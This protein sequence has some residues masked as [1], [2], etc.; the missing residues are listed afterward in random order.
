MRGPGRRW[1]GGLLVAG[2]AL[3]VAAGSCANGSPDNG[4]EDAGR[5]LRDGTTG[6]GATGDGGENGGDSGCGNVGT[7]PA[8]CGACG[9][10][11]AAGLMC[12]GGECGLGCTAPEV[13]C[14]GDGGAPFYDAGQ[15][16]A[17][18]D[19]EGGVPPV[20]DAGSGP[21]VPYCANTGTDTS[22]CGECGKSCGANHTCTSGACILDCPMG[23]IACPSANFCIPPDTC[24]TSADCADAGG[25]QCTSPGGTCGC[26]TPDTLGTTCAMATAPAVL[27]VGDSVTE[28]GSLSTANEENWVHVTFTGNTSLTYHPHIK[29]STNPSSEYVFDLSSSCAGT[30]IACT[31]GG[32]CTSKT[33]WEVSYT[34]TI[35][36]NDVGSG[37]FTA[38][39]PVGAGGQVWI[40]V[41]RA[42]GMPSCDAFTLTISN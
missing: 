41:H 23:T 24:C 40:R 21:H 34:S 37:S 26:A 5:V 42:S 12:S 25:G 18:G 15:P 32:S 28:S 3:V 16:E 7:D 39:P 9:H 10:A 22:N 30:A 29:L 33:E 27:A 14:G 2:L 36:A 11:C 35:T 17:G 4:D 19:A 8:N 38:I 1:T 6:E 20:P 31:E 13:Q